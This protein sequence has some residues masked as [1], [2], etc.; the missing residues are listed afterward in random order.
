MDES[1]FYEDCFC[2]H[3]EGTDIHFTRMKRKF[4]GD[5]RD[6]RGIREEDGWDFW[7][8]LYMRERERESVLVLDLTKICIAVIVCEIRVSRRRVI[9]RPEPS[10]YIFVMAANTRTRFLFEWPSSWPLRG[11]IYTRGLVLNINC[12]ELLLLRGASRKL[13]LKELDLWT[14][15]CSLFPGWRNFGVLFLIY[16][17]SFDGISW[18]IFWQSINNSKRDWN[19]I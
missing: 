4:S 19:V 12:L 2:L 18:I 3:R 16:S 14:G 17:I 10:I 8:A 15:F 1:F 13:G 6:M 5:T 11:E 7:N 9:D